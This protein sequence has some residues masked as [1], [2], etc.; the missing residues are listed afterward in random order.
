MK[1][2][3]AARVATRAARDK[4]KGAVTS[5]SKPHKKINA[6]RVP[7]QTKTM[8]YTEGN[9]AALLVTNLAG[10]RSKKTMAFPTAELALAWCRSHGSNLFYTATNIAHG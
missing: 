6:G 9:P 3:W 1:Q 10:R 4:P 2:K 5:M 8:F 7:V